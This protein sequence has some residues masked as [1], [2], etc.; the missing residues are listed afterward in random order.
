MQECIRNNF[1]R[2]LKNAQLISSSG[3]RLDFI[4]EYCQKELLNRIQSYGEHH[5]NLSKIKRKGLLLYEQGPRFLIELINQQLTFDQ[6]PLSSLLNKQ[7][8]NSLPNA[9]YDTV[10]SNLA[11][12]WVNETDF[13]GQ[14]QNNLIEEGVFWFSAYGPRTM[15]KT[16]SLLSSIEP[17]PHFNDFYDLKDIGDALAGAGFK[18]VI[19]DSTIINLEYESAD[20][21]ICD[22]KQVFGLNMHPKRTRKLTAKITLNRFIEIVEQKIKSE[23]KYQDQVEILIA[24]GLKKSNSMVRVDIPIQTSN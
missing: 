3:E 14:L 15:E 4:A 5:K 18:D 2:K 6:V 7:L 20:R 22:A 24:H 21:L 17:S 10:V 9:Q 23:T 12:D 11:F 16:Q 13:I 19:V 1:K 8:V